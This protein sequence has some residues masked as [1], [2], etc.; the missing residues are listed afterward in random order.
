ME[1]KPIIFIDSNYWIY[2]LDAATIEHI[3]IKNHFKKIFDT[4]KFAINVIVLIE[5]MHY[6][7][8]RLGNQIAQDKWKLFTRIDFICTD[9]IF[10]DLDNIF[11]ELINYSHTGIGGRDATIISSMKTLNITEICTHDKSFQKIPNI[12]VI[13]P[14]P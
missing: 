11:N 13:D 7:V 9:I 3:H 6:L 2:L 14:I 10:E 12:K 1:N 8:R 4:H 5:V